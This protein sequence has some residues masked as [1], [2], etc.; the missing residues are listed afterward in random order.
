MEKTRLKIEKGKVIKTF[1]K[2]FKQTVNYFMKVQKNY[3]NQMD[4]T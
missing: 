2:H 4:Q 3:F 1:Y